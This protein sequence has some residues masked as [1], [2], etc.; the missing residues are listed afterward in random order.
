MPLHRRQY[1]LLA[2]A[3]LTS[4]LAGCASRGGSS[5]NPADRTDTPSVTD[6]LDTATATTA[7]TQTTRPPAVVTVAVGELIERDNLALVVE[8]FQRGISLGEYRTPTAGHEFAQAVLAVKNTSEKYL[9]LTDLFQAQLH[10]ITERNSDETAVAG[11]VTYDQVARHND[12]AT[13]TDGQLAPGEVL[14]GTVPFEVPVDTGSLAL[15][16]DVANA[17]AFESLERVIVDLQSQTDAPHS[18][19]NSL[20][21]T[22]HDPGDTVARDGLEVSVTDHQRTTSLGAGLSAS[23]DTEYVVADVTVTNTGA[24]SQW[25]SPMLQMVLKDADGYTYHELL[26]A[27]AILETPLREGEPLAAGETRRGQVAYEVPTDIS[28][29]YWVFEFA[30]F[31]T[32]D[33]TFWQLQ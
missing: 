11:G 19:S 14:R 4:G 5:E 6:N 27:T 24:D 18:L 25:V 12:I 29:L 15:T 30:L 17:S 13:F 3:A 10:D 26:A 33:K 23:S 7:A 9:S 21:V 8:Q 1:L 32:G 28:T 31:T 16:L 20:Q 2:G 22:V